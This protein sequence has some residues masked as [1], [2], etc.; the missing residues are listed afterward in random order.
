MTETPDDAPPPPY[1]GY[2][3]S[4]VTVLSVVMIVGFLVMIYAI[5]TG[6][7]RRLSVDPSFI[8]LPDGLE[9][10]TFTQADDWY[11]VVTKDGRIFIF[12]RDSGAIRQEVDIN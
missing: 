1:L 10:E 2:L 4:L 12:D 3:K 11:A 5:V 9:I 6:L 8:T 7:P